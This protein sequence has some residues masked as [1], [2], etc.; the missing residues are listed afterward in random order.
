M[1]KKRYNAVYHHL[2]GAGFTFSIDGQPA[3]LR[4]PFEG[5]FH[6]PS[7]R[8]QLEALGLVASADYLQLDLAMSWNL[9]YPL[10]ELPVVSLV[11]PKL[12]YAPER[13]LELA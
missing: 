4:E 11:R 13:G 2:G 5:S 12:A 7:A 6:D 3:L 1:K 10:D 8:Q 9:G